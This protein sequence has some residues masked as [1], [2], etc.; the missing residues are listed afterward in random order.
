MELE[1]E[2]K[3]LLSTGVK[4]V[5]G[6]LNEKDVSS[7]LTGS[8]TRLDLDFVGELKDDDGVF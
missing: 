5:L 7:D 4:G 8:R 6:A 2:G 1:E 3:E